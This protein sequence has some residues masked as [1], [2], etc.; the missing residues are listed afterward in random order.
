LHAERQ[1]VPMG[2]VQA[3]NE[4]ASDG[5]KR[6]PVRAA[7][8]TLGAARAPHGMPADP[9]GALKA[10][11]ELDSRAALR[12]V[13]GRATLLWPA[14]PDVVLKRYER[15]D[16][17]DAWCDWRTRGAVRS[18]ARREAENLVELGE[19]GLPT[20]RAL[21]WCGSDG[22][23]G[24]GRRSALWMERI[25]HRASLREELE[26]R[27][28][29]AARW[30]DELARFT[31]RL[32]AAGWRHRDYYLQHWLVAARGLVLIDV[33]RCEREPRMRE[34]WFVKDLAALHM[35]CPTSVG[36]R[37]RLRFLARYFQ[38]RGFEGRSERRRFA[39]AVRAKALRMAAHEPKH[40][41]A[42]SARVAEASP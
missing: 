40:F 19:L 27:P 9:G 2:G 3:R 31:A 1:T 26:R 12:A 11:F 38:V 18:V 16:W 13:H 39:A 41:D 6:G 28:A 29:A 14:A 33:G 8:C 24:V 30:G 36:P 10:I 23:R 4:G 22:W 7:I 25:E 42:R 34:R 35:S 37:P 15:G 20:P 5:A 21:G 17:R 32:H